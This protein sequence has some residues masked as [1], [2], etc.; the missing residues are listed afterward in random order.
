MSL[1]RRGE[2]WWIAFTTPSG[3][4]VRRSAGTVDRQKAQEL[5]D[6]LKTEVWR[7]QRLG[8][9]PR[10]TWKEAV[11]RY[12]KETSHKATHKEDVANL[13]W[14]DQFLCDAYLDEVNRDMVEHISEAKLATGVA[15]ATVNRMLSTLRALLRK[16]AFEWEWIDRVP[17]VRL[18]RE[19]KRR[20]RWITRQQAEVLLSELPKHL[21]EMA[22]FSLATGLRQRNVTELQWSQVDLD[23]R[24][25]WIHPDQAKSRKAIAVPLNAEALAVVRRQR[26]QHAE[27]VFCYQSRAPLRW[28]G[29][30][31]WR[32]AVKRAG[33]VNFRWHDMRHAWASWHVQQGTPLHVLQELGGWESSEMVKRYAH[34][35]PEHLAEYAER[36]AYIVDERSN[37][38]TILAQPEKC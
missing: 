22:R 23:N 32:N 15:N 13:A 14:M 10:R 20:I 3:K 21:S 37:F 24:R 26:G 5:H 8:E 27:Y 28:V 18:L 31:T 36:I 11:V 38:V 7:V 29:H 25:A 6:R 35:S 16:S 17:K 19:P 2:A 9:K 30:E 12:L 1:Y 4:R 34:L 33:L